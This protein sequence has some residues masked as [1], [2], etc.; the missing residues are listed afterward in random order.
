MSAFS[1]LLSPI[2]LWALLFLLSRV[3][4]WARGTKLSW[5]PAHLGQ[6]VTGRRMVATWSFA[7]RL[8]AELSWIALTLGL[9]AAVPRLPAALSGTPDFPDP[10]SWEPYVDVFGS[11]AVWGGLVLVP[12]AIVRAIAE[13]VPVVGRLL[14]E[15]RWRLPGL[16]VAYVLLSDGGILNVAFTFDGSELLLATTGVLVLSYGALVVRR[17]LHTWEHRARL[18]KVL[19]AQL[20]VLEAAWLALALAAVARLP[21]AVEPV[22][23]GEYDVHPNVAASYLKSLDTLTSVK[24]L[25]VLLPFVL[26]RVLG[27]FQP[28]VERGF[29]FPTGRL[30]I[31]GL[32]Y[33]I[34]SDGGVLSTAL[35]VTVSY[36]WE[37]L[38]LVVALSYAGFV[39]RNVASIELPG[40]YGSLASA[41]VGLTGSL[42][43]AFAAGIAVW[44]GFNHLPIASAALLEHQTTANFGENS[45]PHFGTLFAARY[46]AVGLA[47]AVGFALGLPAL[48]TNRTFRRVQPFL[49]GVSYVTAGCLAWV[50]GSTL[51]PLG[52]GL[53]LGGAAA[54]AG[55]FALAAIQL[56]TYGTTSSNRA[57]VFLA[58]WSLASRVRGVMLG[59]SLAVYV[60]LLRPVLYEALWFAALYEYVALLTV[61]LLTSMYI[62]NQLRLDSNA[63]EEEPPRSSSWSHHLQSLESKADPRSDLTSSLRHRFVDNG[64][65]RPLATYLV[66]LLYRHGASLD[67]MGAV[68]QPLRSAASVSRFLR[69]S[70]LRRMRRMTALETAQSHAE[71]ALTAPAA[72]LHPIEEVD[73]RE[74]AEP[75][76]ERGMDPER[77]AVALIA[78]DCQLRPDLQQAM[79]GWFSLLD[80]AKPRPWWLTLPWMRSE[81]RLQDRQRRLN[82]VDEAASLLF[83]S[84]ADR[85]SSFGWLPYASHRGT[86][87]EGRA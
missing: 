35:S 17:A 42:A 80:A 63:A 34:L 21:A 16:G 10:A 13:V 73:L 83:R 60:L 7:Q 1:F 77:F 25:A 11:L 2:A 29:S 18:T 32:L 22:L 48:P 67:A 36:A 4:S 3:A 20:L 43:Y 87:S 72:A 81:A 33:V 39:L 47:F 57:V 5:L 69:R 71:N 14:A 76:V 51:S 31:L 56:A 12:L 27:V 38:A 45:L 19:R 78:A 41:T 53:V 24:A 28:A 65:W 86:P 23:T 84:G 49:S 54:G 75:F 61:L 62:V 6:K 37:L 85:P 26:L 15:P 82:V 59:A 68:C 44:V 55:L 52:H 9:L 8:L 30:A 70:R 66:G 58:N 74:A 50:V 64:D 40:R 79:D 46:P